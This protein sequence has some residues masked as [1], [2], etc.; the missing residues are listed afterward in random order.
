MTTTTLQHPEDGNF[1]TRVARDR[2]D[3]M[4]ARLLSAT[5]ALYRTEAG[6]GS[7]VI[8]DV[9]SNAGVSRGTFYKYFNSLDEAVAELGS[10]MSGELLGDI[11][12]IF[13]AASNPA[14]RVIGGA[15][16]PMARAAMQPGW[17]AFTS[18]VDYAHPSRH[19]LLQGFTAN[20]LQHAK[21]QGLLA[22]GNL[23]VALDLIV[24]ATL[25]AM[26]RSANG[27]ELGQAHLSELSAMILTGLGGA[28]PA[29]M[30]A[31]EAAWNRLAQNTATLTWWKPLPL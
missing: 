4:R 22:F 5:L 27:Y 29:A 16:M 23:E 1:R 6:S 25:E 13:Q 21:E 7:A 26:R 12:A 20:S 10:E 11:E 8:E 2:R 31:A 17:A 9:I 3:R 14:E 15:L 18:R 24:G 19:H 30:Q 28:R